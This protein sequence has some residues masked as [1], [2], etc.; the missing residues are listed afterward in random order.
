MIRNKNSKIIH[1]REVELELLEDAKPKSN[2]VCAKNGLAG[3][4]A[5][6]DHGTRK[7]HGWDPFVSNS[8]HTSVR[9]QGGQPSAQQCRFSRSV[10]PDDG[11]NLTRSQAQVDVP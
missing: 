8:V 1:Q 6:T 5:L 9:D 3:I 10:W 7:V 2:L 11:D 4:G